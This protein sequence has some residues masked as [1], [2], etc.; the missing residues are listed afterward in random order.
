MKEEKRGEKRVEVLG[1]AMAMA[2]AVVLVVAGAVEEESGGDSPVLR[3][4]IGLE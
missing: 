1:A 4:L 2:V 3:R